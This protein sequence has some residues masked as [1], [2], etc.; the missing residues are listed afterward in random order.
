MIITTDWARNPRKCGRKH[1]VTVAAG[2]DGS[3]VIV[4]LTREDGMKMRLNFSKAEAIAFY[5]D[6][7]AGASLPRGFDPH[8]LMKS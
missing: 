4:V 1:G 8:G 5:Q 7:H 6:L 2:G 3:H